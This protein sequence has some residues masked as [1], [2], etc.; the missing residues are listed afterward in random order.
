[1][2]K[3][4]RLVLGLTKV[5]VDAPFFAV[6]GS[7]LQIA[8]T[9]QLLESAASSLEAARGDWIDRPWPGERPNG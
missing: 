4:W 8:Q 3:V 7:S 5:G 9:Q 6:G 2:A 1:M